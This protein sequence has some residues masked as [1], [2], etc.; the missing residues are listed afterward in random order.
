ME[1][2]RGVHNRTLKKDM[3]FFG[4]NYYCISIKSN[5][6]YENKIHVGPGDI[7]TLDHVN[8][9]V[10][11]Q[12]VMNVSDAHWKDLSTPE[13]REKLAWVVLRHELDYHRSAR[14]NDE[15]TV[16]TWVGETAGYRSVRHVEILASNGARVLTARTTWCPIDAR[17]FKPVRITEEMMSFLLPGTA[18]DNGMQGEPG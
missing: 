3:S 15:L 2:G 13:I 6:I 14:L 12:W 16:R 7:D 11:L 10:Y 1:K 4:K 18:D 17:T 9:V 5:M 8:N